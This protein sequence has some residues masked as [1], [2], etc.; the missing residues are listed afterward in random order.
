MA[1]IDK[2]ELT[3]HEIIQVASECFLKNGY[4]HTT[5]KNICDELGM[6]PGNVTFNFPTKEHLFAELIDLLCDFQ[7]EMMKREANGS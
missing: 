5:I 6:S 7:W 3:R 2:R 4:S 1:K